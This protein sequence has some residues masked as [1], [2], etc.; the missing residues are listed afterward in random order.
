MFAR[1]LHHRRD[2]Y[3]HNHA[4]TSRIYLVGTQRVYKF[5]RTSLLLN[6]AR[7]SNNDSTCILRHPLGLSLL[8]DPTRVVARSRLRER[9]KIAG[10]CGIRRTTTRRIDAPIIRAKRES[11]L[12]PSPAGKKDAARPTNGRF[13][14]SAQINASGTPFSESK[15]F[16][17]PRCGDER[18]R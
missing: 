14:L 18:E 3:K 16:S 11:K 1:D 15:R 10:V 5:A 6:R 17:L 4:L 2:I 13:R 8:A 7:F 9:S 12:N